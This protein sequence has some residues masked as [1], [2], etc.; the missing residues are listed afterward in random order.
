MIYD[1]K[2]IDNKFV[3]LL[4]EEYFSDNNSV[5]NDFYIVKLVE[6]EEKK[7]YRFKV[8]LFRP[9]DTKVDGFTGY[10][11]FYRNKVVMK[12]P[13]LKEIRISEELIEKIIYLFEQVYLRL[14][15]QK[16]L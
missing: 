7:V 5:V 9:T 15:R 4:L 11:Y 6:D 8:W 1:L 16:V 14:G 2:R 12:L 13:G 10:L 3:E